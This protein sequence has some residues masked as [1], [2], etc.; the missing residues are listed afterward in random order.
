MKWSDEVWKKV[1]CIYEDILQL[2]FVKELTA[3]TLDKER[4]LF[5]IR[6]DAI[7]IENYSKVLAHISSRL[8]KKEWR[9]DFLKF[10]LDGIL[11]ENALHASF[12]EIS[13]SKINPT[14]TCLLYCSFESAKGL[15]PIEIETAAILPCF[16][17]Y[18]L[19]GKEIH[20]RSLSDNPYSKW[21]E[22]YAD[23]SFALST[24]KAIDICDQLAANTT[25]VI[26]DK[27][28]EAF[29]MATKM[30]WMFW[31]SAYNLEK[32]KI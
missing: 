9:E 10:A 4:F 31:D 28:T 7:Y 2:P 22:T 18:M 17:I 5:Y 23:E 11:V 30:E 15:D 6:Q 27:M 32:W 13:S 25:E 29:V 20:K 19:V 16:W 1:E 12:T 26:R 24:A 14:P 3:G 8:P 21:I